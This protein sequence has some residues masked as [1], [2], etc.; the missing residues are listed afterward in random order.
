M[1]LFKEVTILQQEMCFRYGVIG[2]CNKQD[3]MDEMQ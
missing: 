2:I 3:Y 1:I